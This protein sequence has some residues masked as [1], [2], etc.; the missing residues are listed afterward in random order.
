MNGMLPNASLSYPMKYGF[1]LAVPPS[2][3]Q[4]SQHSHSAISN[5]SQAN[6]LVVQSNLNSGLF[7]NQQQFL[8]NTCNTAPTVCYVA[9][10]V[11]VN[12]NTVQS[13]ASPQQVVHRAATHHLATSRN[14]LADQVLSVPHSPCFANNHNSNNLPYLARQAL[15]DHHGHGQH[16]NHNRHSS[17]HALSEIVQARNH[18]GNISNEPS[19]NLCTQQRQQTATNPLQTGPQRHGQ[20]DAQPTSTQ[21][22]LNKQETSTTNNDCKP[23]SNSSSNAVPVP[24]VEVKAEYKCPVCSKPFKRKTNLNT[25][26]K[27]HTEYAFICPYCGK[28][29]AR[30]GNLKQH[31]RT[32]TDERPFQC[33]FCR[34]A[35]RQ[36]HSLQDHLRT[37]TGEKPFPCTFCS[38]RFAARCNLIVHERTHTGSTPYHC[39]KCHKKYASKSGLN[40][41]LKKFHPEPEPEM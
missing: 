30:N 35:F 41:H 8:I 31:I 26:A 33:T 28:K 1:N 19:L 20:C 5:S 4:S 25:H 27:V 29:F 36:K 9:V 22:V 24:V 21:T 7:A 14:L 17:Q 32:H 16:H 34:K 40:A 11:A 10:P 3:L 18:R 38:M 13:L 12:M 23:A 6:V 2:Q 15:S 37:H 39:T